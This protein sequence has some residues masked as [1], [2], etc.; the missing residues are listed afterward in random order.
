MMKSVNK[1]KPLKKKELYKIYGGALLF[2]TTFNLRRNIYGKGR[3]R[4]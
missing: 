1:F 4:R 3:E 2:V